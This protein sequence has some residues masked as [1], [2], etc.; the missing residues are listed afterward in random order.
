M[1]AAATA[2][3]QALGASC[4]GEHGRRRVRAARVGHAPWPKRAF[5]LAK[6]RAFAHEFAHAPARTTTAH[7]LLGGEARSDAKTRRFG[8]AEGGCRSRRRRPAP[9]GGGRRL[10]G[11]PWRRARSPPSSC[12]RRSWS[13]RAMRG[14]ARRPGR[15]RVVLVSRYCSQSGSARAGALPLNYLLCCAALTHRLFIH[16]K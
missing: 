11:W 2:A 7:A 3:V 13:C 9:A 15:E 10:S 14:S 4:A 12:A 1:A 6:T 16:K 8:F 5:S